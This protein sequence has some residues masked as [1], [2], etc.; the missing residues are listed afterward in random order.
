MKD[1]NDDVTADILAFPGHKKAP[2]EDGPYLQ[3]VAPGGCWHNAGFIV[4][5]KK[6]Q[7]ECKAC[8]ERLDPLW[9]LRQL[10]SQETRWRRH[11]LQYQDEMA[12]LA[13]RQR[14]KCQHCGQMTRISHH[15]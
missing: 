10:C 8:G 14:T 9:V 4:D 7:V 15:S 1:P 5:E 6:E 11:A 13:A 3:Q 12:R 2:V